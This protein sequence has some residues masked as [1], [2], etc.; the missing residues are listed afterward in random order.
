M[1]LGACASPPRVSTP[2]PSRLEPS[3]S[4]YLDAAIDTLRRVSRHTAAVDWNAL[5]DSAFA[6]AEGAREPRDV[7]VVVDWLLG[8]IDRHSFLQSSRFAARDAT[9]EN[10]VGYVRVPFWSSPAMESRL[11]DTLQTMLKRQSAASACRW[12]V[13]LRSNGGGNMWPMLAGIGPLLGDTLVG[14]SRGPTGRSH[15]KYKNGVS[16]LVH[17]DGREEAMVR[18]SV[19]TVSLDATSPVAVLIDTATGSSGEVMAVAFKGRPNT[20]FFGT[21]TAGVSTTNQGFRLPDGANMVI[22][23]GT[24]VDRRENA[25]GVPVQPDTRVRT[26]LS[27]PSMLKGDP[28]VRAALEWLERRPCE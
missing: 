18:A 17:P 3:I 21:P 4:A 16:S 8:T 24:Y 10:R 6:L 27:G 14:G 28:V 11:A 26:P 2:Q 20:Q 23:V 5:R 12:I 19:S 9:L 7:Y 25:Y 1:L 13:D 15:W 22:T